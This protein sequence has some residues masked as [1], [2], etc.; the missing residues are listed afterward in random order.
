MQ[1]CIHFGA[2][3]AASTVVQQSFAKVRDHL[4]L[5]C[6]LRFAFAPDFHTGAFYTFFYER[7]Y[8]DLAPGPLPQEILDELRAD[9]DRLGD[10][11]PDGETLLISA[12]G[13]LGHCSLDKYG[14]IY[15]HAPR[16]LQA[17]REVTREHA[18]RV[19]MIVRRQDTFIESCYLQQLKAGRTV[20][21]HDF[22][23]THAIDTEK[24]SWKVI[25]DTAADL[26]G[27]ADT[28]VLPFEEIRKGP[29]YIFDPLATFLTGAPIPELVEAS[30]RVATNT[31]ISG[32][33]VEV[34]L[35]TYPLLRGRL[36]E[37]DFRA[38]RLNLFNRFSSRQYPRAILLSETQR[39]E[40]LAI[41]ASDN[42][43]LFRNHMPDLDPAYYAG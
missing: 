29:D 37:E 16:M 23:H 41:C 38:W 32:L 24:L 8:L 22:L 1:L 4:A 10:G 20:T 42:A 11:M 34:A 19:V 40:I 25:A 30:T 26:F 36:S 18:T 6:G 31:A 13:L 9:L 7:K 15:P 21:F 3:K 12:E 43:A 28:L 5:S 27:A 35:A 17:L 39:A 33:G 2:H 14:G